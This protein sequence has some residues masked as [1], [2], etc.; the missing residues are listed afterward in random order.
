MDI[1]EK[2]NW[3]CDIDNY[4][5]HKIDWEALAISLCAKKPKIIAAVGWFTLDKPI[6]FINFQKGICNDVPFFLYQG[7]G[8]IYLENFLGLLK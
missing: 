2:F 1:C 7:G 6:H 3:F 5:N 4:R 8:K